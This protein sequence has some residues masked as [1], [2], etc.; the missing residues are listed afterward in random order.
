MPRKLYQGKIYTSPPKYKATKY[1]KDHKDHWAVFYHKDVYGL[2]S[3]I[4]NPKI[5]PLISNCSQAEARDHVKRLT[6][7]EKENVKG[8]N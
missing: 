7:E 1:L 3:P 8:D 5:K 6:A 2:K 4:V